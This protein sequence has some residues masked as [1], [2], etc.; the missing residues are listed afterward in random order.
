MVIPDQN[1]HWS[2]GARSQYSWRSAADSRTHP[3]SAEF[4]ATIDATPLRWLPPT[5]WVAYFPTADSG[6]PIDQPTHDNWR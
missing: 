2:V 4:S 1:D 5:V 3:G 6:L